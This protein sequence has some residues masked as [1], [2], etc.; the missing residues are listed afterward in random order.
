MKIQLF[1][2]DD[3]KR[4]EDTIAK[5][6]VRALRTVMKEGTIPGYRPPAPEAF[7]AAQPEPAPSPI[8]P[9]PQ[10]EPD[11]PSFGRHMGEPQSGHG[12]Y[13]QQYKERNGG[14]HPIAAAMVKQPEPKPEPEPK[15]WSA[16]DVCASTDTKPPGYITADEAATLIDMRPDSARAMVSQWLRARTI[17]GVIVCKSGLT[18][19]KGLPGRLFVEKASVVAREKLRAENSAI[20]RQRGSGHFAQAAE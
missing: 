10:P 12:S 11:P 7:A 2:D 19:T 6:L 16:K 13:T 17:K 8:R 14:T 18:P 9:T 4:F 3:L 15:R 20:M 5:A 1:D